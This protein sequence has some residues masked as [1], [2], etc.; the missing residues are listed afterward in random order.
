MRTLVLNAGYEPIAVVSDRRA[1]VLVLGGKAA[2]LEAD[3]AAPLRSQTAEYARP[4][5]ILLNRYVRIPMTRRLPVS[6]K[7]VLRRDNNQCA[8]CGRFANTIDH[9][10]PRSRGGADSWENLVACCLRCNNIK[11]DR[12]P[13]EMGWTLRRRPVAPL[14]HGLHVRGVDRDAAPQ[15]AP[16]LAAKAA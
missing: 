14:M 1:L 13:E 8:Y 16:Y 10:Q 9:V 2:L 5:V 3:A 15:W 4:Q 12:T 7:G 6:R 11:G